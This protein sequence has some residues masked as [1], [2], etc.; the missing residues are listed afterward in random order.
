MGNRRRSHAKR[1]WHA[2]ASSNEGVDN[3]QGYRNDLKIFGV[4]Q[5]FTS[6]LS[7]T[8]AIAKGPI[9]PITVR[10]VAL[11]LDPAAFAE[12]A[13]ALRDG[14]VA[15]GSIADTDKVMIRADEESEV[16][17][18]FI[19]FTNALGE[20]PEGVLAVHTNFQNEGEERS[21]KSG[22]VP[23]PSAYADGRHR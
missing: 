10:E 19:A 13:I 11:P 20:R 21:W 8:D 4:D 15:A 22:E 6:F 7:F 9:R 12:Q 1:V 14:L 3:L 17:S 16:E 2:L 18:L 23:D 5:S